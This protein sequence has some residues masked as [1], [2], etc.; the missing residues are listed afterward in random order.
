MKPRGIRDLDHRGNLNRRPERF[1]LGASIQVSAV[2]LIPYTPMV[3]SYNVF[4]L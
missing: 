2:I 4:I 1:A 3:S